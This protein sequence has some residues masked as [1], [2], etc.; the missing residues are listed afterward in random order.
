MGMILDFLYRYT[1]YSKNV[2]RTKNLHHSDY[3]P[4][5]LSEPPID[6][7]VKMGTVMQ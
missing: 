2:L 6:Q 7:R 5:I 3:M 1:N 4:Q